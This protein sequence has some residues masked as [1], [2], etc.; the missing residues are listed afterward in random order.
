MKTTGLVITVSIILAG[1]AFAQ[2][3]QATSPEKTAV[4]ANDRA[5]ET[6]YAKADAKALAGFFA[7]DADYT[8]D[9]GRI[10]SGREA[11]EGAKPPAG[12]TRPATSPMPS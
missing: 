4:V 1:A 10:F 2:D 8:T 9:D 3:P 12:D 5:Y 11:I 7:E 6:A